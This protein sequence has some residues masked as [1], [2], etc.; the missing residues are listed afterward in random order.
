V[1]FQYFNTVIACIDTI[2]SVDS[3]C[4]DGVDTQ[5]IVMQKNL[6]KYQKQ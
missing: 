6:S 1:I 4:R 3:I 5:Y 2:E